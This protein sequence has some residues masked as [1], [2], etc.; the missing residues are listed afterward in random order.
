MNAVIHALPVSHAP[1]GPL[2]SPPHPFSSSE[3]STYLK[4]A[5]L[6]YFKSFAYITLNFFPSVCVKETKY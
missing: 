2:T 4:L 5:G 1:L 6:G 3:P